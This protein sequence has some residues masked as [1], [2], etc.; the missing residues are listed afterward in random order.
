MPKRQINIGHPD[1]GH[2]G[3]TGHQSIETQARGNKE[4]KIKEL[5]QRKHEKAQRKFNARV[6]REINGIVSKAEL[7]IH[8]VADKAFANVKKQI[9]DPKKFALC[10]L[11][12]DEFV[13]REIKKLFETNPVLAP[14]V[15]KEFWTPKLRD[16]YGWLA[17]GQKSNLL[18]ILL[19][20]KIDVKKQQKILR[21]VR[22]QSQNV[23]KWEVGRMT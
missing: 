4:A 19:G 15:T 10:A 14:H 13:F 23:T 12:I 18:S 6:E 3:K 11:A 2:G 21:D 16:E 20:K 8:P 5:I 9:K 7:E 22:A 17:A 1:H